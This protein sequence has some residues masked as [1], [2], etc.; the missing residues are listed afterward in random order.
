MSES[1]NETVLVTGAN[2]MLG[3]NIVHALHSDGYKI[4]ALIFPGTPTST[5]D[6]VQPDIIE[7]DLTK[8][9][10]LDTILAGCDR[11]IHV[12]AST[13]IWPRRSQKIWDINVDATMNLARATQKAGIKRFVHIGTANSFALGTKENPGNEEGPFVADKY[14]LDY[15]DSKYAV[16][17]QLLELHAQEN[18]PVVIVNPTF[19]IGPYDSGPTSGTMILES[20]KGKIQGYGTGG[21]NF[22]HAADVA[23]AAVNALTMGR[24]GQ[25]YIAG[26]ENLDYKEF[27]QIINDNMGGKITYIKAPY[28]L[29]LLGGTLLSSIAMITGKAP[30]LSYTMA[31]MS[32]EYNYY[33]PAKAVKELNMPQTP[34]SV[35]VKDCMD[36]FKANGYIK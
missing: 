7:A 15:I 34:I 2:G 24:E 27:A 1:A 16:Q 13:T 10:D 12:A 14:K 11:I 17:Q 8:I 23:R 3:S 22:V 5:I 29:A 33:S 18:F 32:K 25:C 31:L 20:V 36:W 19:M 30:K 26:G 6:A 35:A 28:F 4:K 21:K 9:D